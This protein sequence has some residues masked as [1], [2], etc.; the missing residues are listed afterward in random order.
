MEYLREKYR[1]I[2]QV[3]EEEEAKALNLSNEKHHSK[4][5]LKPELRLHLEEMSLNRGSKNQSVLVQ[6][7]SKRSSIMMMK[8]G[9]GQHNYPA[10]NPALKGKE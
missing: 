1:Q 8:G 5:Q 2:K 3:V 9:D 10:T 4:V 7:S 6:S